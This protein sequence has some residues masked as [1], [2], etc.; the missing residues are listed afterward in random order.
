MPRNQT[1]RWTSPEDKLLLELDAGGEPTKRIAIQ[2]ERSERAVSQRISRL[3]AAR[4]SRQSFG[5][6]VAD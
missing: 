5:K 3:K 6:R 4:Q 2:L 1:R